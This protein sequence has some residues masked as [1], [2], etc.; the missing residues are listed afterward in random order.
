ML[1]SLEKAARR[2]SDSLTSRSA[3]FSR[4]VFFCRKTLHSNG[5]PAVRLRRTASKPFYTHLLPTLCYT[6]NGI[7]HAGTRPKNRR[8]YTMKAILYASVV[9]ACL[10]MMGCSSPASTVR[11]GDPADAPM[12]G[13]TNACEQ[14]T[15]F[16]LVPTRSYSGQSSSDGAWTRTVQERVSGYSVY[17]YGE[18]TPEDLRDVLP[19]MGEPELERAQ[20]GR[21]SG[22]ANRAERSNRFMRWGLYLAGGGVAAYL[23]G[24]PIEVGMVGSLSGL[25]LSVASVLTDPSEDERAYAFPRLYTLS[26]NEIDINAAQRGVNRMNAETRQRCANRQDR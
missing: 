1:L 4:Q 15:W 24:A 2:H 3:G 10:F 5:N 18:E 26:P 7:F 13:P 19:L 11:L 8:L 23:A 12:G 25:G 17:R 14:A 6:A 21:T 9:V 22:I 20:L 16:E